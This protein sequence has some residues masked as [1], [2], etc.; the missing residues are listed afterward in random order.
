EKYQGWPGI[1]NGGIIASLIDCHCMGTAAAAAYRAE[2]RQLGTEPEYRYATGTMNIRYLKPTPNDK[3][4]ELRARVTEIKG[5]KTVLH[6]AFYAGGQM[7]AEAEIVGIRVY[8][9]SK[10]ENGAFGG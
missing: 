5:R 1:L 10:V 7:T 9:S 6:C 8:D 4:V 2:G 3:T